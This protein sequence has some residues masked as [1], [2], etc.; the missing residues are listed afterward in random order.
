MAEGLD[1][2]KPRAEAEVFNDAGHAK[3]HVSPKTDGSVAVPADWNGEML[4]PELKAV[5]KDSC[6]VDMRSQF[7]FACSKYNYNHVP[8]LPGG[9][10]PGQGL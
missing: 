10:W 9:L 6:R 4:Q 8:R 7:G 3:H 1:P 5:V 2:E